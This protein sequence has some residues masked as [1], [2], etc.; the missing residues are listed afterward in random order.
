MLPHSELVLNFPPLCVLPHV[1]LLITWWHSFMLSLETHHHSVALAAVECQEWAT[2]LA[3]LLCV[4]HHHC[5]NHF[6]QTVLLP[7]TQRFGCL[8]TCLNN[9]KGFILT[10]F[11]ICETAAGCTASTMSPLTSE[12]LVEIILNQ[13]FSVKTVNYLLA[14]ASLLETML[15][16]FS[17]KLQ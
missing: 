14:P 7:S 13:F 11:I 5:N 8:S 4:P 16:L 17:I 10:H 1:V 9:F 2:V 15:P 12:L 6:T 3:Q